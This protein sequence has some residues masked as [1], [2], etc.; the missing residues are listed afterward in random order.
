MAESTSPP[1]HHHHQGLGTPLEVGSPPWLSGL[2]EGVSQA[3]SAHFASGK[4]Q[5]TMLRA[6]ACLGGL[7]PLSVH[8]VRMLGAQES[9]QPGMAEEEDDRLHGGGRKRP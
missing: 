3:E 2:G 8:L 5:P 9:K 1:P 6:W 7:P 4:G